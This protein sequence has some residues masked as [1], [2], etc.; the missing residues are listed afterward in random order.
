[1]WLDGRAGKGERETPIHQTLSEQEREGRH[2]HIS[3]D[4]VLPGQVDQKPRRRDD[5]GDAQ[6]AGSERETFANTT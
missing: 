3:A 6:R 5:Y 2:L 1:M 4:S